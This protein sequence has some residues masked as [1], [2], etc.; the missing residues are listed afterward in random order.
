MQQ[1]DEA[2]VARKLNNTDNIVFK[3]NFNTYLFACFLLSL[4]IVGHHL[5]RSY[6]KDKH[7]PVYYIKV[8]IRKLFLQNKKN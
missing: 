3:T 7:Y 6:H 4:S 2:N 1:T 8:L 5:T